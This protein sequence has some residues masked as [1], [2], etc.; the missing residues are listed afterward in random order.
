MVIYHNIKR[1]LYAVTSREACGPTM[2]ISNY[3]DPVLFLSHGCKR[4]MCDYDI[5]E[6][7]IFMIEA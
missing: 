1:K 3:A 6:Y 5:R 4:S 7:W 2:L